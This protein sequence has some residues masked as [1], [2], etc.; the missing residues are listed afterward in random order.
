MMH[1]STNIN[2]TVIFMDESFMCTIF[3]Y[4]LLHFWHCAPGTLSPKHSE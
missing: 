3:K 1:G 4:A 2:R